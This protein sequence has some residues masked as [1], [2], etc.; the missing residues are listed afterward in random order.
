MDV[1][2]GTAD[3][4]ALVDNILGEDTSKSAGSGSNASARA[5]DVPAPRPARLGL[6]AKFVPHSQGVQSS[7][8]QQSIERAK[9]R[10]AKRAERD[11]E[12]SDAEE[13]AGAAAE[14]ADSSDE[15]G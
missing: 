10:R 1:S 8:L 6:G 13:D 14:P 7:A 11:G 2:F 4:S 5:G 12:D 9:R 15:E 3:A